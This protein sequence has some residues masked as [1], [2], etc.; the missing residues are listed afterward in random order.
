MILNQLLR[1]TGL[2][3]ILCCFSGCREKE[4]L[5]LKGPEYFKYNIGSYRYYRIDSVAYS[6]FKDKPD[7][8]RFW[9]KE[10]VVEAF[11][12]QAGKSALRLEQ[13]RKNDY[14][15]SGWQFLK[16]L[17]INLDSFTAQRMEDNKRVVSLVFPI[18]KNRK[19]NGN[20]YNN[21]P[22]F[23]DFKYVSIFQPYN[24]EFLSFV[25]VVKVNQK[26]METFVK[27]D[28]CNEY[29]AKNVG[30]IYRDEIVLDKQESGGKLY[31]D[32]YEKYI[33]LTG[34]KN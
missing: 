23:Q 28:V 20:L 4:T 29:Y 6:R 16:V 21:T 1:L 18:T 11:V 27:T 14:D 30:L 9:I 12:D 13:Q 5:I 25:D 2:L 26:N 3:I 31:I 10:S 32:G 7:S 8:F 19:W 24:M 33:Q 34:Y 17:S 15:S 22:Y